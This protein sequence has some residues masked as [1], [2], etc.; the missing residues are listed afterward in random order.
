[1]NIQTESCFVVIGGH[2]S[3]YV[4]GRPF[5]HYKFSCLSSRSKFI[6]SAKVDFWCSIKFVTIS[7]KTHKQHSETLQ[8]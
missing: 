2:L 5:Q 8:V 6:M 1:V 3:N 4:S 7:Y